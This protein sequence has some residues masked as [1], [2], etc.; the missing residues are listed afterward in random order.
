MDP[1]INYSRNPLANEPG[2]EKGFSQARKILSKRID[3]DVDT[4]GK[5]SNNPGLLNELKEAIKIMAI[6][7]KLRIW[8]KIEF[9]EKKPIGL[10][11]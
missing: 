8:P 11:V 9:Q 6:Q 1:K 4:I 2:A 7:R 5:A 10:L 3:E